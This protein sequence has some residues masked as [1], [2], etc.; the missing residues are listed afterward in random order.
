[1]RRRNLLL[2]AALL[3]PGVARAQPFPSRPLRVVVPFVP[4]GI[5]DILARA[6]AERLSRELGQPV[7]VDNRPGAGGNVGSEAVAKAPA[8]GYTLLAVG[9]AVMRIAKPLYARLTYDPDADFACLGP[10]SAQAKVMLVSPRA[11]PE[12]TLAA[13]LAAE[14]QP[15]AATVRRGSARAD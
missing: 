2:A 11:L 5:T 9:P 12:P 14:R 15:W 13:F 4:G 3:A 7:M 1:M 8:D 6:A 10:L